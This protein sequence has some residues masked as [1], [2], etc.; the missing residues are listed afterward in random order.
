MEEEKKTVD[1]GN[2]RTAEQINV[3][4]QIIAAGDDPFSWENIAKYHKREILKKGAF[5]LVTENQWPYKN[6]R[7]Q[8]LFIYKENAT[9]ISELPGDAFKELLEFTQ[10]FSEKYDVLG[11]GLCMRFGKTEY[12]GATVLHL[13]AQLISPEENTQCI[14]YIGSQQQKEK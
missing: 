11:G 3:M 13:H 6:S 7:V 14:F 2:A 1:I 12:S 8:I 9:T 4:Q 5:W 10:E